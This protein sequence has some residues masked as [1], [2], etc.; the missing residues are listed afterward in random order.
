MFPKRKR[1]SKT[2]ADVNQ[3]VSVPR[4]NC[5]LVVENLALHLLVQTR[6]RKCLDGLQLLWSPQSLCAGTMQPQTGRN[7]RL[8]FTDEGTEFL[9]ELGV[10]VSKSYG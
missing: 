1:I 2:C 4:I 7:Y 5:K 3:L 8:Y 6:P 10:T 9:R